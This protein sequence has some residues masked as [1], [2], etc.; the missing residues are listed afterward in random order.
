MMGLSAAFL[1]RAGLALKPA[2]GLARRLGALRMA[3]SDEVCMS[4]GRRGR[5][6][7]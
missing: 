7:T 3:S 1:N 6:D 2:S 5:V 4:V